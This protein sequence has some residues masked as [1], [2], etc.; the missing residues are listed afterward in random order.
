[1]KKDGEIVTN[2]NLYTLQM[3]ARLLE[4][5]DNG[6]ALQER[7][8]GLDDPDGSVSFDD[9][10]NACMASGGTS[11]LPA[12]SASSAPAAAVS[13]AGQVSA[14]GSPASSC[15]EMRISDTGLQ[16]VA[17]HEGYSA[18]AYR[19]VDTQNLTIGY[20]HVLQPEETYSDL[21]QPQAMGLLKS[22]LSTYEDAV[23][24]EFSGTKL[25]QNQFDA[26]V[27]FSYN[28][29]A[30]IWSKAPQFTSDVKNG[31]SADVLKA[32]FERISYCNGHQVQ[33]LVNRRLDE[34]RLF[35]GQS[36]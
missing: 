12:A 25:T 19:G 32:D 11:S 5:M 3:Q 6:A 33:G 22:D 24:R 20:G 31:A 18:T 29:G 21:T 13:D 34:F 8:A 1:M 4:A 7:T 36:V 15:G 30:N 2:V 23:N 26:L 16:F 10:L 35:E 28:L 27:S 14:A 9:L 17:E